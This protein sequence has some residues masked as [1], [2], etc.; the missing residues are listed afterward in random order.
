MANND[1][2]LAIRIKTDANQAYA[3]IARMAS[4]ASSASKAFERLA[5]G[6]RI[7]SSSTAG[8]S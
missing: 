7:T 8:L 1:I 2:A 4:A 6:A 3:D 5:Q